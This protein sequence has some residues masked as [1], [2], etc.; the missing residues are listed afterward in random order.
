MKNHCQT[1]LITYHVKKI[2]CLILSKY[3]I[4]K[5]LAALTVE[6]GSYTYVDKL[7]QSTSKDIALYH[8]REALRDFHSLMN[9]GFEKAKDL[10]ETISFT[11][12]EEELNEIRKKESLIEL[13]EVVSLI[14]S[15][16]LSEA[17]RLMSKE[18]YELANKVVDKLKELGKYKENVEELKKEI[19]NNAALLAKELGEPEERIKEIAEK[20]S[21]LKYIVKKKGE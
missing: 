2:W 20:T 17:A 15:Q 19:L 14:T 10:V 12:V 7:A 1:K 9:R 16:A 13:R 18:L 6:Q 4:S 11:K 8:I 5:I 21:L 3:E